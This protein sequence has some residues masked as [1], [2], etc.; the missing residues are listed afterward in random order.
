MQFVPIGVSYA[1]KQGAKILHT[2]M[3][4]HITA[5]IRCNMGCDE[6]CPSQKEQQK[7]TEREDQNLTS[8]REKMAQLKARQDAILARDKK[9]QRV[10]RTRRLIQ[11]GA[12][13]EKYLHCEGMPPQEFEKVLKKLVTTGENVH[14]NTHNTNLKS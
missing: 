1:I 12:L 6:V 9:R 2:K 8:I 5:C 13:A 3:H 14:I 7:M 4:P 11:N 10:E